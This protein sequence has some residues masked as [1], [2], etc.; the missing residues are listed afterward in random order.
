MSIALYLTL[1]VAS[2]D[3]TQTLP[4]WS[5]KNRG[6]LEKAAREGKKTAQLELGRR[7]EKGIGVTKDTCKALKWYKKAAE[8]SIDRNFVYSGPVGSERHGRAIEVGMPQF[9]PG[10]LEAKNKLNLLICNGS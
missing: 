10:L 3:M 9:Q 8:D 6:D 4:D 2:S 5:I 7:Y 1:T